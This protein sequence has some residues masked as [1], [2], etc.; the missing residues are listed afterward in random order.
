MQAQAADSGQLPPSCL[1]CLLRRGDCSAQAVQ[2]VPAAAA[3]AA[4]ARIR[5]CRHRQSKLAHLIYEQLPL[6]CQVAALRLGGGCSLLQPADLGLTGR[7]PVPQLGCLQEGTRSKGPCARH[8]SLHRQ[9]MGC[10]RAYQTCDATFYG[11]AMAC[12]QAHLSAWNAA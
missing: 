3:V 8:L 6:S 1:H 2:L 11:T 4:D 9:G 5:L 12:M 7:E 10:T